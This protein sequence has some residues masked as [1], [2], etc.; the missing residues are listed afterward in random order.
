[1]PLVEVLAE[2]E[3]NGILVDTEF[4][5]RLGERYTARIEEI[6]A[7]VYRIAGTEFNLNSPKQV[8]DV[9]FHTLNLPRSKKTKVGSFETNVDVLE[10]LAREHPIARRI[11][12]HRE[13]S[14]LLST[15]ILALP[16]EVNPV[17][18]RVHIRYTVGWAV[19][20]SPGYLLVRAWDYMADECAA[21]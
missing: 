19:M 5:A 18:G 17:T 1:M 12:D 11:L 9:L 15:Y 20:A 3:W 6:T 7:E 2:L 4:L 16:A 21:S 14:K 13:A 8:S 10:R